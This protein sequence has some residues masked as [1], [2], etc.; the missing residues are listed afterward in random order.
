MMPCLNT[1]KCQVASRSFGASSHLWHINYW[2]CAFSVNQHAGICASPPAFDS[3]GQPISKCT[4]ET[5]KYQTGDQ[6]EMNKFDDMMAYLQGVAPGFS[7]LVAVDRDFTLFTRIWCIAELMQASQSRIPQSVK[8]LSDDCIAEHLEELEEL[9]VRNAQASFPADRDFILS[10][11]E[12]PERFNEELRELILNPHS[13]LLSNW[14]PG[15][16]FSRSIH[17]GAQKS[18]QL[19]VHE[20]MRMIV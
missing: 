18:L 3:H 14:M 4:C 7:Q 19:A 10:K 17:S 5:E 8:T 2:V 9:D 1:S 15:V 11:V 20:A 12:D 16:S 6:C 13:G